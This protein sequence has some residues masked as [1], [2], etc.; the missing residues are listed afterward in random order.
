MTVK[1]A[2]PGGLAGVEV[3]VNVPG[4]PSWLTRIL[5]RRPHLAFLRDLM[6]MRA[7]DAVRQPAV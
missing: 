5:H 2:I 4:L 3:P 1:V 7:T 6:E